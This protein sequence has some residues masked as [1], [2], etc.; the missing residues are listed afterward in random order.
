M[1]IS[2]GF[3]PIARSDARILILGSLP[4]K[5]S[6]DA[7]QYYAHERNVFWRIMADLYAAQG[8][9]QQRC[10]ALLDARV[11]VWDVLRQSVRPGSLDANIRI[12]SAVANDFDGFLAAHPQLQRI[13]FNGR[14]AEALFRRLVLP[15]LKRDVCKL[16][17]LPS[18]SP[19]HA[20][21]PFDK[22]LAIWRSMLLDY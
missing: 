13:G 4:G 22:K 6:L 19:A 18:T 14:K 8:D 16:V 11:A 9:Y 3:E 2:T 1:S 7:S 5:K 20:A 17:L 21:L 10:L 15:S 12:D